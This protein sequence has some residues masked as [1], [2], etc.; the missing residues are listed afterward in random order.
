M[1][2]N[3]EAQRSGKERSV[4]ETQIDCGLLGK[5]RSTC[6]TTAQTKKGRSQKSKAPQLLPLVNTHET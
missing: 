1:L 2:A 6:R 4:A 5:Y 3:A